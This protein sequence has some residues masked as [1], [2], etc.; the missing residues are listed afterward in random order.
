MVPSGGLSL[1]M[2]SFRVFCV[3]MLLSLSCAAQVQWPG[4]PAGKQA[5]AWLDAFNRGDRDAYLAFLQKNMPD[6]IKM[7]D[8]EMGFR[9]GTG[10]FDLKKVE[11]AS[12]PT[13]IVALVQERASDQMARLTMEVAADEPHAITGMGLRAI[14]RPAD[15]PLPHMSQAELITSVKKQLEKE[16]AAG[17]FSGT[18]LIASGGKPV[19]EQAYGVADR[20]SKTRNT[21]GT[22]FRIGSMNK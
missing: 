2:K 8:A 22:Q 5:A 12:A 20:A 4:T 7:I 18:M 9:S 19:F 10:G 16:S 6:R 21:V 15:F 1:H 13:K 11:D 17:H 3:A 14:Q